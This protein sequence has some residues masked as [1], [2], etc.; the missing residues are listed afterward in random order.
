MRSHKIYASDNIHNNL[1]TACLYHKHVIRAVM[2]YCL[3]RYWTVI[4]GMN[5]EDGYKGCTY[6]EV[7]M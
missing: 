6:M 4:L 3:G 1:P 5:I 7:G 2:T